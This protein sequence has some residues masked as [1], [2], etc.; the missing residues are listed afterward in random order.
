MNIVNVNKDNFLNV[1]AY[2][3]KKKIKAA[4][5]TTHIG[6]NGHMQARLLKGITIILRINKNNIYTGWDDQIEDITEILDANTI[7]VLK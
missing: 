5:G 6:L 7:E 3:N 1:L 4:S 2:F